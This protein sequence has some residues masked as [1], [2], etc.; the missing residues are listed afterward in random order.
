MR[1][2]VPPLTVMHICTLS[3]EIRYRQPK[4]SL[5]YN[6]REMPV[7]INSSW[8]E[9]LLDFSGIDTLDVL[10]IALLDACSLSEEI[11]CLGDAL[12]ESG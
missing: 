2:Q 8:K 12:V 10:H 9:K 4:P 1:I 3:V 6:I 5:T 7:K 11:L